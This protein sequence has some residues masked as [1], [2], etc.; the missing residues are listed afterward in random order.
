MLY[1][2]I[3]RFKNGDAAPIYARF[4]A[5]GRMLPD[6]LTYV[7]SWVDASRTRCFQ[8]METADPSTFDLWIARWADLAEFEV[9]PVVTSAA[10]A[11]GWPA[12]AAVTGSRKE[13]W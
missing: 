11:A 4:H 9:I 2:V 5:H 3:E 1:L 10:A 6:G 7:N 12:S 8:L 13:P